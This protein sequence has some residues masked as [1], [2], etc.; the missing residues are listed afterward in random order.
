[1]SLVSK[2][3][4]TLAVVLAIAPFACARTSS[5]VAQAKDPDVPVPCIQA[6]PEARYRNYAYDHIV[7]VFN[8]CA[9]WAT[10]DVSTDVNPEPIRVRLR[11][12]EHQEVLTFRGSPSSEFVPNV[13]C[14]LD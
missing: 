9:R 1:M 11:P 4:K 3:W 13:R 10:C 12:R 14:W 2:C 8:G 7:H 6:W 5:S